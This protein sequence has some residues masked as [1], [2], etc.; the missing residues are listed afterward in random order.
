MNNYSNPNNPIKTH[1]TVKSG[2]HDRFGINA[3]ST[4]SID[5]FIKDFAS[6]KAYLTNR[7]WE[8]NQITDRVKTSKLMV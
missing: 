2:L 8:A 3:N 6:L 5:L 4:I 1:I 7:F